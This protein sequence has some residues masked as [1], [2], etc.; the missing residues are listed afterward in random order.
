[1]T[2]HDL[3]AA[4]EKYGISATRKTIYKDIETLNR[5]GFEVLCDKSRSNHY[6]VM[7]RKFERPE[8]Q[9]LLQAIG[10]AK[11]LSEQK[12]SALSQKVA[13][14]LGDSQRARLIGTVAETGSKNRNEHIYYNIDAVTSAIL[15]S[16]KLSFLY[17]DIDVKGQRI[18]RKEK[19][20]YIVNP[21]GMIYSGDYFYLVC[22]H[23]KYKATTNYR[24][25]KMDNVCVEKDKITISKEYEHFDLNEYKRETFSMYAG[26]K[27]EITLFF[28]EEYAG[29]IRDRFGED[30]NIVSHNDG[31]L[32]HTVVRISKTFFAWLTSF[33]GRVKIIS[34]GSV[35]DSF[36]SFIQKI[37][38]SL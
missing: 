1:M 20:R 38:K 12:A 13:E 36:S 17:F 29:I 31:Y 19:E 9:I 32:L 11:F 21:L 8:I 25:D 24:I 23:E 5:Y 35:K 14:L 34:P 33:E 10:A 16:K 2:T 18:Y 7:D 15:E 27:T 37:E 26:E 30:L 4:L 22:Y 3:A 28:P 6:Y